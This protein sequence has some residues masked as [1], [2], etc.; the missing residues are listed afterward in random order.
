[1]NDTEEPLKVCLVASAGGHLTQLRKLANAWTGY[2]S[3]W[4]T[5]TEVVRNSLKGEGTVYVVGECNRQHLGRVFMVFIRC[6][7][8]IRKEKPAVVIST[9]AAP[10]CIAAILGKLRG[11]RVV[12]L[13]SI[14][15]VKH[16][17]LSG[18]MVRPFADLFLVQWPELTTKYRRV[19]YVGEVI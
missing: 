14:T 12:W 9:G 2:S 13:D 10:G 4:I 5:S 11:A 3:F 15:N 17:S 7:R 16:L 6:L 1:M 8:A 18:R 19:V